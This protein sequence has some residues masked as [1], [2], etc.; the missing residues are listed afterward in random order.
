VVVHPHTHQR[1]RAR[2][3]SKCQ[4]VLASAFFFINLFFV[5]RLN[6][7]IIGGIVAG[8]SC[9]LVVT[10]VS[11][12]W[13]YRRRHRK[14]NVLPHDVLQAEFASEDG[15]GGDATDSSTRLTPFLNHTITPYPTAPSEAPPSLPSIGYDFAAF[16][17]GPP[18]YPSLYQTGS[19]PSSAPRF[20]VNN[21]D[22][23]ELGSRSLA[24]AAEEK[25]RL[26]VAIGKREN[27]MGDFEP[28]GVLVSGTGDS[29][30]PPGY[31]LAT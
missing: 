23:G 16:G 11:L 13:W 10:I 29:G 15:D 30:M 18:L 21:G 5:L 7:G 27:R 2:L 8:I 20:I 6:G 24:D 14:P 25:R 12:F 9:L 3:R 28:G 19:G 31:H 17:D 4:W 1:P 22:G 26:A